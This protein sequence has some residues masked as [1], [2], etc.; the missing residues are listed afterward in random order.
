MK[1]PDLEIN[2]NN[3]ATTNSTNKSLFFFLLKNIIAIV[4]KNTKPRTKPSV[5]SNGTKNPPGTGPKNNS[6]SAWNDE[7]N[8]KARVMVIK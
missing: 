3:K 6:Y 2:P 5:F 1:S 7:D 8:T 4:I